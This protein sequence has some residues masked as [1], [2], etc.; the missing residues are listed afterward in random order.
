MS[1]DERLSGE[2]L[3]NITPTPT[4]VTQV[5]VSEE[6]LQIEFGVCIIL[7]GM[8]ITILFIYS[9]VAVNTDGGSTNNTSLLTNLTTLGVQ[10]DASTTVPSGGGEGS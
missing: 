9:L 5:T 3:V 8:L 4:P 1:N 6:S 10:A 7:T 2:T